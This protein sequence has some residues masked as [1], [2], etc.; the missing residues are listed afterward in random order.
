MLTANTEI[1]RS[2][3]SEKRRAISS[4]IELRNLF[5]DDTLRKKKIK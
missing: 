1:P 2:Q 5:D 3:N 4:R